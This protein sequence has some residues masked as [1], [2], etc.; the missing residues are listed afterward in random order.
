MPRYDM[1]GPMGGGPFTGR[2]FGYC[3]QRAFGAMGYGRGVARG[4]GR[5]MGY[6]RGMGLRRGPGFGPVYYDVPDL[7]EKELLE[8]EK[9]YLEE[10]LDAIKKTLSKMD[11]E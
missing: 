6:G 9:A 3:A 7:S 11:S 1:T 10:Q 8:D 5:G 4:A 2:G